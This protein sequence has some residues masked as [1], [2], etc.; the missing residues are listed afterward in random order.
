MTDTARN[1]RDDFLSPTY[2]TNETSELLQVFENF[3]VLHQSTV[4]LKEKEPIGQG[5]MCLRIAVGF[6]LTGNSEIATRNCAIPTR[7]TQIPVRNCEFLTRDSQFP[8][9]N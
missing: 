8:T 4:I 3:F 2:K 5:F 1:F 6:M 9:G 7:K